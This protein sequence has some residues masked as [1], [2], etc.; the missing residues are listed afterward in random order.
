MTGIPGSSH[1]LIN[2][3]AATPE[4]A[5][6]LAGRIASAGEDLL[7]LERRFA[8]DKTCRQLALPG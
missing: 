6:P 4:T 8:A 2:T 7:Q 5:R 3:P 1:W